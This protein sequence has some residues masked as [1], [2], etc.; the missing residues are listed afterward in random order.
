MAPIEQKEL[1]DTLSKLALKKQLSSNMMSNNST[2][3]TTRSKNSSFIV[4]P[5]AA[6]TSPTLT[7]KKTGSLLNPVG[8]FVNVNPMATRPLLNTKLSTSTPILPPLRSHTERTSVS[9]D[10]TPT[11]P[12]ATTPTPPSGASSFVPGI[13]KSAT[14][15]LSKQDIPQV[16]LTMHILVFLTIYTQRPNKPPPT[17]TKSSDNEP[18]KES[19]PSSENRRN[20][21]AD[22]LA[23]PKNRPTPPPRVDS[24]STL[25]IGAQKNG[26]PSSVDNKSITDGNGSLSVRP[27]RPSR[28][29]PV[30]T[31]FQAQQ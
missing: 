14:I 16:H 3:T 24:H 12:K 15:I 18:T 28:P 29:A 25:S 23:K 9:T 26:N 5:S 21:S 8:G 1:Q 30:Q 11:P 22:Q 4:G 27:P 31:V 13:K 19:T 10:T 6:D 17:L 7:A 2:S 20:S